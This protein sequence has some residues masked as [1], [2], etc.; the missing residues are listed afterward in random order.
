MLPEKRVLVTGSSGFIGTNLVN[1]LLNGGEYQLCLIDRAEP[2]VKRHEKFFTRCDINSPKEIDKV[3][4]EFKPTE[5]IHL[6]ACTRIIRSHDLSKYKSNIVGTYNLCK[7]AKKFSPNAHLI[8]TSSMLAGDIKSKSSES[9]L[10][11]FPETDYGLSKLL[12]EKIIQTSGLQNISIVRLSSIWGEWQGEPFYNFFRFIG[13][14]LFFFPVLQGRKT[15]RYVND[16]VQDILFLV[17]HSKCSDSQITYIGD[18]SPTSI[19]V[20]AESI[21]KAYD[22]KLFWLNLPTKILTLAGRMGDLITSV[23][24]YAPLTS[25]RISNMSRDIIIN[26]DL[27]MERSAHQTPMQKAISN[28]VFWMRQKN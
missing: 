3:V 7:A 8:Y 28:T 19:T 13:I 10:H 21:A 26:N 25:K 11:G 15:L 17:T 18:S 12:G 24:L 16:A 1:S 6:A 5:I 14:G 22:S 9:Q 27:L 20:W 23:G 4:Y 2:K